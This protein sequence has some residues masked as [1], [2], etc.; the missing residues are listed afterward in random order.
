MTR[1]V[2]SNNNMKPL[3]EQEKGQPQPKR[4]TTTSTATKST[5]TTTTTTFPDLPGEIRN[6]IYSHLYRIEPGCY[7]LGGEG[8]GG[9]DGEQRRQQQQQEQQDF[10]VPWYSVRDHRGPGRLYG[11]G[12][13]SMMRVNRR[14]FFFSLLSSYCVLFCSPPCFKK[15]KFSGFSLFFFSFFLFLR[16][17]VCVCAC[18]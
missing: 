13:L 18:T 9:G 15:K 3:Q 14:E 11:C 12:I 6:E 8:E 16:R 10:I 7:V 5:T 1:V 17:G 4:T 2:K